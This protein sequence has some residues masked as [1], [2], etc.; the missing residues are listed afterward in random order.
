VADFNAFHVRDGVVGAGRAVEAD[1]EI[2][3]SGFG[4]G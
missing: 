4:L 3:G 1:T 2:A